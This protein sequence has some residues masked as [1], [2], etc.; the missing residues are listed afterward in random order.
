MENFIQFSAEL[1]EQTALITGYSNKDWATLKKVNKTIVAWSSDLAKIFTE[2]LYS[3]PNTAKILATVNRTDHQQAFAVWYETMAAGEP[4]ETF[5]PETCMIGLYHA[6]AGVDNRH[7]VAMIYKL[8]ISFQRL[9]LDNFSGD[10]ANEIYLAFKRIVGVAL[11]IMIDSYHFANVTGMKAVGV[12]EALFTRIRNLSIGKMIEE[13]RREL[14]LIEWND[15]LSVGLDVIDEQHIKLVEILNSLNS[16][17]G[18]QDD[19]VIKKIL[20]DLVEYT[21]YHFAFEEELLLKH[22]YPDYKNHVAAHKALVKKVGKFNEEFQA[23]K[24]KLSGELFKFLR[25]WLNGHIRG[26]DKLYVPHLIERG[27]K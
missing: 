7:V 5:W 2:S 18:G 8:E 24:A 14:P 11:A 22:Q 16:S 27:V 3:D 12:N 13:A 4:G 20:N 6:A 19:E 21:V 17:G 10:E 25:S 1:V 15:S 23:G 9:C 26:T